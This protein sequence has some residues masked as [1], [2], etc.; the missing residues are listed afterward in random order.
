[1]SDQ[2]AFFVDGGTLPVHTPSYVTRASD[3]ELLHRAL[4]GAFCYVLTARQ[5][6]KS[7]LMVRTALSLRR[8]G[9]KTAL[10][11]LTSIGIVSANEWYLGL[12]MRIRNDLRIPI[13]L[14]A[15]WRETAGFERAAPVYRLPARCAAD[16]HGRRCGRIY[17]RN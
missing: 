14:H 17:R 15:W 13:D 12:L 3:Q 1:M 4:E 6:G 7:S 16:A 10:V 8:Y 2:T 9:V 5:M 11:D